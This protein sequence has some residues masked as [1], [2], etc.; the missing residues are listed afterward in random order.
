VSATVPPNSALVRR[1]TDLERRLAILEGGALRVVRAPIRF[2]GSD[3]TECSLRVEDGSLVGCIEATSVSTDSG[4]RSAPL[5]PWHFTDGSSPAPAITAVDSRP[6]VAPWACS[7]V[8]FTFS[9]GAG[10]T[11]TTLQFKSG[12]M[13]VAV[14]IPSSTTATVAN[15]PS[16][17]AVPAGG[18]LI[19]GCSVPGGHTGVVV[20][21][22]GTIT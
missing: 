22:F 17:L 20:Q 13:T 3:G 16:A 5:P 10:T 14:S 18:S 9:G 12:T 8:G 19:I 11:A 1:F 15:L 4:L 21:P 6:W 2:Q 7:V